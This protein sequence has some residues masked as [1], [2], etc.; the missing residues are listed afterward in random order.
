MGVAQQPHAD[1]QPLGVTQLLLN[2][3]E[4]TQ[5]IGHLLHI[6]SVSD[7]ESGF[8]V[9]QIGQGGLRALDLGCQQGF[10]ADGAVQQPIH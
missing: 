6:V 9:E 5:V 4:G 8:F 1:R 3:A 7:L 2:P 10:L